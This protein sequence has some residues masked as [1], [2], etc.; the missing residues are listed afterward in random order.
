MSKKTAVYYVSGGFSTTSATDKL[1][2]DEAGLG[3]VLTDDTCTVYV[4]QRRNGDG[5]T[6]EH[7]FI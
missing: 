4:E 2:A 3:D 6:V 1:E 5:G 7:V